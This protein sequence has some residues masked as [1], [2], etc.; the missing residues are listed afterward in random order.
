MN[1]NANEADAEEMDAWLSLDDDEN[2]WI[3]DKGHKAGKVPFDSFVESSC[4]DM[5]AE[6]AR[7]WVN[8]IRAFADKLEQIAIA[9][10]AGS[11]PTTPAES[12]AGEGL[13]ASPVRGYSANVQDHESPDVKVGTRS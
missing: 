10:S 1:A 3:S 8:K 5:S 7:R 2:L 4:E 12:P 11:K 6:L 9:D 13:G